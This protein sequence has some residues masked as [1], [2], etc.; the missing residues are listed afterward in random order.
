[1]ISVMREPG[2]KALG[3]MSAFSTTRGIPIVG[4]D[5]CEASRAAERSASMLPNLECRAGA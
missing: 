5:D 3:C 2:I 4:D 1:M